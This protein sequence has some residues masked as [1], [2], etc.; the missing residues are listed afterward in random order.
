MK[1]INYPTVEKSRYSI[2]DEGRVYNNKTQK[3]LKSSIDSHGYLIIPLKTD[4]G[5]YKNFY[6]A[7][8]VAFEFCEMKDG[9]NIVNHMD[10]NPLN[11]HYSNLE[12]TDYAGN[13]QHSISSGS[14]NLNGDNSPTSK[15]ERKLVEEICELLSSGLTMKEVFNFYRPGLKTSDDKGLYILIQRIRQKTVWKN[16][17]SGFEFDMNETKT[18]K[19]AYKFNK[20]MIIK[21]IDL[22]LT[23][24]NIMRTY[25]FK[26]IKESKES[27]ALYDKIRRIRKSG[28]SSTTIERVLLFVPK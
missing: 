6:I 14:I 12:W 28:E 7:R 3:W 15:Y 9:M 4:D 8:L 20:D 26:S 11:N 5:K 17:V 27:E 2:T 19:L 21:M 16:V 10:E 1:N 23:N 25:G 13:R 18:S 22:G 24:M